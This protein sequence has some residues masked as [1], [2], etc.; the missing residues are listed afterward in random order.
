VENEFFYGM[1]GVLVKYYFKSVAMRWR[2]AKKYPKINDVIFL[3]TPKLNL[4]TT[5]V[6]LL[7]CGLLLFM[8]QQSQLTCWKFS[9]GGR[10]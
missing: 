8:Q 1:T 6:S 9:V 7:I 3:T 10:P 2:G 4:K 5:Q